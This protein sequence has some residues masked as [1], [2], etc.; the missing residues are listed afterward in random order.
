MKK[1]LLFSLILFS[2]NMVS[3]QSVRTLLFEEFTQ[4]SCPPCEAT[5]PA[6]TQR[7]E[8]NHGKYVE[9]RYQTSW[10]G[11]DP[12]NA[13]NPAE[14]Q[15]RVEYYGVSGVPSPWL[16]G[17][18]AEGGVFPELLNQAEIEE[19]Y[20]LTSPV[21]VNV[22]H[23]LSADEAT[24]NVTV[25]VIN[26][27][28]ADYDLGNDY[29]RVALIEELISWDTPPGST[30]ITDYEAVLKTFFTTP[31]GMEMP[32]VAAGETWEMTWTDLAMPTTIYDINTIATIAFIQN[33]DN[34]QVVN[35]ATTNPK[36]LV[37][38]VF[39]LAAVNATENNGG[40]CD[41][42]ISPVVTVVNS[43]TATMENY[44]VS[45][46]INDV[47]IATL[48]N[49]GAIE[50]LTSMDIAFDT[51][52]VDPGSSVVG[53][54][55]D[56]EEDAI[57]EYNNTSAG[58]AIGK[59][60]PATD[61]FSKD[62]ES[63]ALGFAP[64]GM[65]SE[66]PTGIFT[67]SNA[68][69][70]GASP[71]GGYGESDVSARVNFF[72]WNPATASSSTGFMVVAD[73]LQIES[74][75]SSVTFDYAFTTWGSSNDGMAVQVST[76]CGDSFTTEWEASGSALATAPELNSN[77]GGFL[78]GSDQWETV[79]VDLSEYEGEAVLIRFFFTSGWGDMMYIDNINAFGVSAIDDLET[80]ESLTVYPNP[81]TDL[82]NINVTSN[83]QDDINLRVINLLGQTMK[84][85]RVAENH[86]GTSTYNLNTS[87]LEAGIYNL[88]F[89]MGDKEVVRRIV[90]Q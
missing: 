23:E 73:Q 43:G 55:V 4:A 42:E 64:E 34:R 65:I 20:A 19:N 54:V 6:L 26:E 85:E 22:S 81:V 67:V 59:A 77:T 89:Q 68:L 80:D 16:E 2:F 21:L 32:A 50:A 79:N 56:A 74:D 71:L 82:L 15:A 35:A 25:Q 58:L 29:L 3:A 8:A 75:F 37:D 36:D 10:P 61:D 17:S 53:F 69:L 66:T 14:V 7:L 86:S 45:L 18:A 28:T 70:G 12:M 38:D 90:V 49:P 63:V 11:V 48:D 60:G 40:L 88:Y 24:I 52:T 27:G 76:D 57:V 47:E 46:I 30:S 78:P 87:D 44:S 1:I 83:S 41:F 72:Q 33:D 84:V 62:F 39:D 13:D 5:T 51:Y 31:A 9:I